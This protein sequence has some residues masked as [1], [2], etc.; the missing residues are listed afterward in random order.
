[1]CMQIKIIFKNKIVLLQS[2]LKTLNFLCA[3][4]KRSPKNSILKKEQ[5]LNFKQSFR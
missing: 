2:E 5:K 4:K 3:V 1:M